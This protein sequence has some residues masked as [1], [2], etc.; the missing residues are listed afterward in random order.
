MNISE[1]HEIFDRAIF[2]KNNYKKI[3]NDKTNKET[4]NIQNL[5]EYVGTK[6]YL[7]NNNNH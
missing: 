5:L 2:L 7:N 1:M 3:C 4:Q 6:D